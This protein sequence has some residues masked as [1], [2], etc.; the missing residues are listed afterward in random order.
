MA[1]D[2]DL[3]GQYVMGD[4]AA[5]DQYGEPVARITVRPPAPYN[6]DYREPDFPLPD[7]APDQLVRPQPYF[8]SEAPQGR[9][10]RP[11]RCPRLWAC[12]TPTAPYGAI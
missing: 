8:G 4:I 10:M 3:E 9:W 12:P 2:D 1:D 11:G 7:V 5:Q 6:P